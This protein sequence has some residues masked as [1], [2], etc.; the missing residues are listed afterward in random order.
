MP[1]PEIKEWVLIIKDC[2]LGLAALVTIMVAIYGVRAWKRDLVGKGAY[3]AAKELVKESHLIEKSARMLWLPVYPYEQ[4]LFTEEEIKN[5]TEN[6]RWRL[7]EAEAYRNRIG[8]F[9]KEIERYESVKLELRVLV[10]SKIYEGFQHFGSLLTEAINRV[11]DYLNVIQD[12]SRTV[13]ID[14]NE[15]IAAQDA[16]Y[17]SQNNDDELSQR[18]TDARET[19]EVSL[20][21]YLHRKSIRG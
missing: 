8:V 7:S 3:T 17:P 9:A 18:L 14:S 2:L 15:V 19:G 10:G 5:T 16:L 12:H 13:L 11:N 20:L 4:K 6:E 21:S 1:D